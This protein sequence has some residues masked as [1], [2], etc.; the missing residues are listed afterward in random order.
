[1]FFCFVFVLRPTRSTPTDALFPYPTLF[2]S[3]GARRWFKHL[4]VRADARGL[5]SEPGERDGCAE[6]LHFDLMLAAIGLGRE[7]AFEAPKRGECIG[8]SQSD[9]SPVARGFEEDDLCGLER[10][11]GI[12]HRPRSEEYT[13]ELQSLM[14]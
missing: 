10:V 3:A 12:A 8:T 4:I 7:S 14:R 1:M 5:C 2:R 6:L 9:A 11:I 13:S